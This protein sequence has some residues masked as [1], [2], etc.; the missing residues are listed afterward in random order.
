MNL[1]KEEFVLL[2]TG[3]K[4]VFEKM[5]LYYKE[6]IYN[7]LL[8]K[9]MGNKEVANEV[10]SE[11]FYSALTGIK[12][13]KSPDNIGGWLCT[14]ASRRF[15]DFLRKKY[16]EKKYYDFTDRNNLDGV[17]SIE[18]DDKSKSLLFEIAFE[19]LKKE[20]KDLIRMKYLEDKSQKEISDIIGKNEGAIEGLL[21]RARE[22]L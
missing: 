14:I 19:A 10:F 2:K 7:F 15:N 8:F 20:Y 21:F 17:A 22:A 6:K 13:I 1:S 16:R 4:K 12:N 3:D 5:Y 18:E 11:T 9:A